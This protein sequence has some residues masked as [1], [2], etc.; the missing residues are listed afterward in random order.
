MNKTVLITLFGSVSENSIHKIKNLC[1]IPFYDFVMPRG[2]Y[3]VNGHSPLSYLMQSLGDNIQ[4]AFFVCN[5]EYQQIIIII[6]FFPFLKCHPLFSLRERSTCMNK[7]KDDE[8]ASITQY[9]TVLWR[10]VLVSFVAP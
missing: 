4:N 7:C 10:F 9:P 6:V 5:S 2:Y 3:V 1:F 8:S